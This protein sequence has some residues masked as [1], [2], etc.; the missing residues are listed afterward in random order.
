[1]LLRARQSILSDPSATMIGPTKPQPIYKSK[2][3][4][5]AEYKEE[6]FRR[7]RNVAAQRGR[8]HGVTSPQGGADLGLR[9]PHDQEAG[10]IKTARAMT[11]N[12]TTYLADD[13]CVFALT[14]YM[15]AR[16]RAQTKLL[17]R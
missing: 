10:L 16:D 2:L 5:A 12:I 17:S 6:S 3:T 7:M 14:Q 8:R 4:L 11:A 9:E 1:M 15:R 13:I